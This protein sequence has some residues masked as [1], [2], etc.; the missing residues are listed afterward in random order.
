MI[1]IENQ[2]LR[3]TM[4]DG[5]KW[6][7]PVMVIARHRAAEYADEFDNDVERS[8][9]EDTLP[10]FEKNSW[11]IK[12]WAAGNMDWDDVKDHAVKAEDRRPLTDKDFQHGWVNGEK[13]IV[14]LK[15]ERN[16]L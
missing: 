6:D 1:K 11:E 7:V 3:A 4:P 8:L 5:S 16:K 15:P 14:E 12:H 13:A 10:L 2:Y 9:K